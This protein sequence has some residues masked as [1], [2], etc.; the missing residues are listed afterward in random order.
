M[1]PLLEV[2][3]LRVAF[4]SP[5]GRVAAVRGV[6]FQLHAG[7][8]LALVGES[9]SGKS[10][11]A[12]SILRLLPASGRI[13]G[14][15][16]RFGEEDLVRVR[17]RSLRRIRGGRIAIVFQDSM[18]SLNPLL[19]VGRQ[20]TESL[21]THAGLRG[22]AARRRA[23]ELLDEVGVPDPVR[24]LKQFPHQLSG[25]LRQRVAIAIALAPSPDLLI[26]D[27]PTTALDVTLQA[28]L[29]ELL[30]REQRDR[31]MALLMITHDFGVVSSFADRVAV[32]Y[33]GRVVEHGQTETLFAHP[34]HP[35]TL[36]L[37]RSVPRIDNEL[38]DRLPAIP[39]SP[40][41]MSRLEDGCPFHSRC[42]FALPRCATTEPD[43]AARDDEGHAAACWADVRS[44]VR[45]A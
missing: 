29:L 17:P 35:Y 3:D 18:A 41:N 14:G 40:P 6:T 44:L 34:R 25:G 38:P 45:S 43:L 10:T 30:R 11:I 1:A 8:T 27:E 39:G 32:M 13:V 12:L 20:I 42:P 21:E 5:E 22:N 15:V 24:R 9:G 7:E 37:L 19:T 26:A 23:A 16:I 33:A 31:E 2:D 4:S 36:G 28:Q